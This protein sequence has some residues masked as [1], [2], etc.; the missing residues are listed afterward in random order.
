MTCDNFNGKVVNPNG[1]SQQVYHSLVKYLETAVTFEEIPDEITL[2]INITNCKMKCEGCHSPELRLNIGEWLSTD[3]L[4]RLISENDGI[5]CVCFMGEG[6]DKDGIIEL[7]GHMVSNHPNLKRAIYYGRD[8]LDNDY[9][10]FNYVKY[11]HYDAKAGP[12]N[13]E[14]T[15]QRLIEYNHNDGIGGNWYWRDITH[16]FWKRE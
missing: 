5:T 4:D 15:N 10:I 12:L 16:K 13:K 7:A 6:N 1:G 11:G 8:E 9:Q 14:T 2:A 3:E